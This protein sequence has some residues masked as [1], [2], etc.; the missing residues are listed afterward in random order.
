MRTAAP[1]VLALLTA[2]DDAPP[3]PR[4]G[5]PVTEATTSLTAV[6]RRPT[7]SV[8]LEHE[9]SRCSVYW[10]EA[11]LSSQRKAVLC[12]RDLAVGERLRLTGRTCQRE[13]SD[14][15]RA[16]PVRC[17]QALLKVEAALEEGSGEFKLAPQP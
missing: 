17:A 1:L 4:A 3:P 2:C 6:V 15:L 8:F 13:S 9:E 10:Q 11:E 14:P 7:P 5:G 16:G 12:P